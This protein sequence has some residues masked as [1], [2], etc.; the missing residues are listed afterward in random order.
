MAMAMFD[1]VTVSIGELT[2]GAL[3]DSFRVRG[4]IVSTSDASKSM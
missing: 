4:D 1:S 3:S 2:K